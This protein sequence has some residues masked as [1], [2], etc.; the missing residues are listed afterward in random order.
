M[1]VLSLI[2]VASLVGYFAWTKLPTKPNSKPSYSQMDSRGSE[3]L[4][5][6]KMPVS[7]FPLHCQLLNEKTYTFR[8]DSKGSLTNFK[9]SPDADPLEAN[10]KLS[11]A[12][13]LALTC[14][15]E[16]STISKWKM[17]FKISDF[18]NFKYQFF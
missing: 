1:K 4:V 12:G 8:Y 15:A 5:A 14:V 10:T 9:V 17:Q 7:T 16:T 3:N 2:V 18:F 6:E 11:F 13:T